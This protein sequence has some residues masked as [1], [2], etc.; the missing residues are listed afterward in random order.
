MFA[1]APKHLLRPIALC[2]VVTLFIGCGPDS[3]A[4]LPPSAHQGV[5]VLGAKFVDAS[6][7]VSGMRN[8][9]FKSPYSCL[10][11]ARQGDGTYKRRQVWLHIPAELRDPSWHSNRPR[12]MAT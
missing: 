9:K 5:T 2:I 3:T 10:V 7:G 4:P 8:V 12:S 11:T 1:E 6:M